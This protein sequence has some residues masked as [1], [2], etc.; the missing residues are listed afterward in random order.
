LGAITNKA[1]AIARSGFFSWFRAATARARS[2]RHEVTP[3]PPLSLLLIAGSARDLHLFLA[4]LRELPEFRQITH[5]ATLSAGLSLL[6][7][8]DFDAVLV[9]L[10]LPDSEGL[11]TFRR[12]HKANEG[13]AIIVL[14]AVEDTALGIEAVKAGAQDYLVKWQLTV[15]G[16]ARALHYAIERNHLRVISR[17]SREQLKRLALSLQAVREAERTRIAREIHDRLGQEL[18]AL[19]MH[20]GWINT[21]LGEGLDPAGTEKIRARVRETLALADQ[22]VDAVGTIAIELRPAILDQFGL[23]EAIRGEAHRFAEKS[24]VRV[25]L[26]LPDLAVAFS[27]EAATA[28]FRIV[29][30]LFS[31]IARHAQ[32]Q[33]ARVR[34]A[35]DADGWILEVAD[36]GVGMPPRCQAGAQLFGAARNPRA[37]R[38]LRWIGFVR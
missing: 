20:L 6:R 18:I 23:G 26:S 29:Q 17:D 2:L 32:A 12:L 21:G 37:G 36:D 35:A 19:K 22:I 15:S 31:N 7:E 5:V 30:E 34:L 13:A 16:L 27:D 10:K 9:D 25:Q 11:H 24:G 1:T 33:T 4:Q 38:V 8:R 28:C 14:T 3:E